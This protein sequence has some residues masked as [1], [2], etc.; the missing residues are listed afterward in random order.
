GVEAVLHRDVV[1]D[2]ELPGVDAFGGDHLGGHVS[3]HAVA[4]VV[5]DQH[6][7]AGIRSALL[8]RLV[9]GIDRRRG[10]HRALA[11]AGE[12]AGAHGHDVRRLVAGARTLHDRN[13]GIV[14]AALADYHLELGRV[15]QQVRVGEGDAL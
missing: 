6:Q 14:H 2:P 15:V 1:I 5:V 10:E 8:D 3:G 9:A 13:L 12:H 7:H 4:L 11:G